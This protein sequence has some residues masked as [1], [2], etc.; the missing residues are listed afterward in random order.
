MSDEAIIQVENLGKRYSLRHSPTRRFLSDGFGVY[1]I[2]NPYGRVYIGHTVDFLQRIDM[3]NANRVRSTKNAGPWSLICWQGCRTRHEA[4]W[5]E[6][7]LKRSHVRR[8][9][10]IRENRVTG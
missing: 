3:H 8:A 10:W 7:Q 5:L 6:F 4:R 9:R 2:E 1:A